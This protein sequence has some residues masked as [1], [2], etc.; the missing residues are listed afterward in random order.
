MRTSTVPSVECVSRF[1]AVEL[2]RH[3]VDVFGGARIDPVLRW[4]PIVYS[5]LPP[6]FGPVIVG[7]CRQSA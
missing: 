2:A 4:K 1:D 6:A 7:R 5:G 3:P